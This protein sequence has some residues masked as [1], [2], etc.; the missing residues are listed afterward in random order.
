MQGN[1]AHFFYI[2]VRSIDCIRHLLTQHFTDA[3][4][5]TL[6]L[7]AATM[8]EPNKARPLVSQNFLDAPSQRI[9]AVGLAAV[10]QVFNL[11]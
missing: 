6:D 2:L 10:F 1:S 11:I 4:H 5:V 7:H 8:A 3:Y 9:L